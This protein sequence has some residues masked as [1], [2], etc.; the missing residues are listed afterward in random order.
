M[1]TFAALFEFYSWAIPYR[2]LGSRK[3]PDESTWDEII[4]SKD[5]TIFTVFLEDSAGLVGAGG[6]FLGIFLGRAFKNPYLDPVASIVIGLLLAAVA[7]FLGRESG[8]LRVGE[9]TN[10]ARIRRVK[11]IITADPSVDKVGD[12]LTM[13]LGPNQV[14]LTGI[15][16]SSGI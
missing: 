4:G 10:R 3:D 2:E 13:Q 6:A 11:K 12:L 5:P 15:F 9:R 1:L 14:L 16:S 8:A 7:I